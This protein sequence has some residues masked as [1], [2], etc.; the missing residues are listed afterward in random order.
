MFMSSK[1]PSDSSKVK[2]SGSNK[3]NIRRK[4]DSKTF[5]DIMS[6]DFEGDLAQYE[7]DHSLDDGDMKSQSDSIETYLT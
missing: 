5:D 6:N 2:N 1:E 7:S 3:E 4:K